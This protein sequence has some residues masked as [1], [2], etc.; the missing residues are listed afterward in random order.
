MSDVIVAGVNADIAT[1]RKAWRKT[2]AWRAESAD[3]ITPALA[4]DVMAALAHDILLARAPRTANVVN[5]LL[6]WISWQ[7]GKARI[8]VPSTEV[9]MRGADDPDLVIPLFES[10]S[11]LLRK[12]LDT[13]R[14]IILRAGG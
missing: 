13:I 7:E 3:I 12:Y 9:K 10:T 6:D 11:R 2:H 14:P 4:Q 1:R 5:C 8:V